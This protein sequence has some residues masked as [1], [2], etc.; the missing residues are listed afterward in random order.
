MGT[1]RYRIRFRTV[2]NWYGR[3][4]LCV[5]C[6]SNLEPS[7][8]MYLRPKE[9]QFP[10]TAASAELGHVDQISDLVRSQFSLV[11]LTEVLGVLFVCLLLLGLFVCLLVFI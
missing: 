11:R 4:S 5:C 7:T 9:G 1:R 8:A 3:S 2:V 6:G 10:N